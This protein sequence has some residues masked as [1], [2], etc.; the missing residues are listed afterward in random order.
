MRSILVHM[1]DDE[2]LDGRLAVAGDL[3]RAF[4]GH[5]TCLNAIPYEA[6]A[7]GEPFGLAFA[8]MIPV[9]RE[10]AAKLKERVTTDLANEDFAWD[11]I[12]QSGTA[13]PCLLHNAT[14]ADVVVMGT[15]EPKIGGGAPSATL[16]AFITHTRTPTLVV[17]EGCDKIEVGAP[18]FVAWNGYP[19]GSNALRAAMPLLQ[20][21]SKVY[22]ASVDEGQDEPGRDFPRLDGAHYL[23]RHDI[24]AEVI[25]LP[26]SDK[27]VADVLAEAAVARDAGLMVMGA[28][29]RSRLSEMVFG[30]VT[31]QM[32]KS[33]PMPVL[34]AH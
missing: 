27:K 33:P 2:G 20:R 31:R 7:P 30:G 3:A 22:L 4:E 13:Y 16:G 15:A 5:V 18:A 8:A 28:Y 14:L 23:A 11:Y 10:N 26:K 34:M 6:S 21:A 25:S 12:E 9:M 19:E 24:E 32:L 1:Y 29:G 17:P